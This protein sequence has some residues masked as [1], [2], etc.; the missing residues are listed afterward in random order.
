M[1]EGDKKGKKKKIPRSIR[2]KNHD[3]IQSE[4]WKERAWMT[5][6]NTK[7]RPHKMKPKTTPKNHKNLKQKPQ[8]RIE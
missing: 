3:Q 7:G 1:I 8:K 4:T 6:Y 2:R 5:K